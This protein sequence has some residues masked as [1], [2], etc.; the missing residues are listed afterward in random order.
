MLS[1]YTQHGS[2]LALINIVSEKVADM[3]VNYVAP[4]DGNRGRSA[5]GRRYTNLANV[6][7]AFPTIGFPGLVP[8]LVICPWWGPVL[9]NNKSHAL[10]WDWQRTVPAYR[11]D[12][13]Q[14]S[15]LLVGK[16]GMSTC[17]RIMQLPSLIQLLAL[18]WREVRELAPNPGVQ[19]PWIVSSLLSHVVN[20]EL[21][22]HC[23]WPGGRCG[24][25]R[26]KQKE[27]KKYRWVECQNEQ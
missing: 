1:V 16:G 20:R 22:S 8:V 11:R 19:L 23:I 24:I 18:V 12:G 9:E 15:Q 14:L 25:Q 6:L 7:L 3:G 26:A 4:L 13:V 2:A 5:R 27:R 17:S 21:E 10:V